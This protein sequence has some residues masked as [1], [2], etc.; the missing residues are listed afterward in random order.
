MSGEALLMAAP[1]L[2]CP[3]FNISE[4]IDKYL[5]CC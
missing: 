2:F 3:Y 5:E 4:V 1:L